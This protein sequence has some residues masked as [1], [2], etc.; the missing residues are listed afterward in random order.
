MIELINIFNPGVP[1]TD[2]PPFP[3]PQSTTI[4]K[5]DQGQ[6]DK[7]QRLRRLSGAVAGS[8]FSAA[9]ISAI[10]EIIADGSY[11]SPDRIRVTVDRLLAILA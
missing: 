3:N 7:A 4:N 5:Q 1:Q 6:V 8:R 9:R 11:E 10:R 2:Y